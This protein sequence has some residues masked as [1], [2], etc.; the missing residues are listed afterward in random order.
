M[1]GY[2]ERMISLKIFVTESLIKVKIFFESICRKHLAGTLY[3]DGWIR[4]QKKDRKHNLLNGV[5]CINTKNP[6]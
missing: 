4:L 2:A 5:Q 1:T 6:E 3:M